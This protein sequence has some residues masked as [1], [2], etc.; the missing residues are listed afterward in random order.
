MKR[1]I[2]LWILVSSFLTRF[3]WASPVKVWHETVPGAATQVK[4]EGVLKASPDDVW[5]YLIR[6][7]EYDRF[8]PRVIESFFI[9]EEGVQALKKAPTRNANRLRHVARP[10]KID[11]Q[12]QTGQIWKGFVFMVVDAPFPVEN[13]WYVLKMTMD[14]SRSNEH[15][16]E[17][18]W[19]LV[20]GN[21]K[22]ADGCWSVEPA[23]EGS[24]SVSHYQDHINLG[25]KVP[26]WVSR[27]GATQT[28][29]QMFESLE[30]VA[31][32]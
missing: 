9:S 2:I 18:C 24:F 32:K 13:R 5:K 30:K 27:I 3:L 28:V 7:N 22:S 8:M 23:K 10:F 11:L 26:E 25:G 16:Y 15:R 12:E 31:R 1:K 6:F 29:P 17:R 20:A 21:I 19:T 14:E 4:A